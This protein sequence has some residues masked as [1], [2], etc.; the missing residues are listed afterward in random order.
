[1]IC[2]VGVG[3][4]LLGV[5]VTYSDYRRWLTRV[6]LQRL[7]ELADQVIA[8]TEAQERHRQEMHRL[9]FLEPEPEE[10]PEEQPTFWEFL[11]EHGTTVEELLGTQSQEIL[12]LRA[13]SPG[14]RMR[15][16]NAWALLHP[17]PPRSLHSEAMASE[18][19]RRRTADSQPPR[20]EHHLP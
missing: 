11:H 13:V 20:P 4:A 16:A 1:M 14:I 9:I 15:I 6:R 5:Y 2:V 12:E 17:R 7:R 19:T 10:N 3:L 18:E 8:E